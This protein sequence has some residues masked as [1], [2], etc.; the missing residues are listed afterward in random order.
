MTD[1]TKLTG[2]TG[3]YIKVKKLDDGSYGLADAAFR[4][5]IEH[6]HSEFEAR[7]DDVII[8]AYPKSG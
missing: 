8:C 1:F 7:D 2:P 3:A 6:V 5:D 4:E